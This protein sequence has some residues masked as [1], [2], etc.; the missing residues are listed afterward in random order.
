M[1]NNR[2]PRF[3]LH[4]RP[5]LRLLDR[6]KM[7]EARGFDLWSYDDVVA[8]ATGIHERVQG[9]MPPLN[10]GGLWPFEWVQV[11][12]RWMSTGFRRLQ[13]GQPTGQGY[14]ASLNGSRVN[15]ACETVL[16][17]EDYEGWL[18]PESDGTGNIDVT[19]FWQDP[20][21]PAVPPPLPRTTISEVSL[22]LPA[23]GNIIVRDLD[24]VHFVP[25]P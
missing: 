17:D 4:I 11:F 3:E 19:L 6:D 9:N 2:V 23:S 18:Q 12:E 13:L 16:P 20:D 15:L 21:E 14:I 7:L 8:H 1:D 10:F 25:V 22:P 5:L 24:G